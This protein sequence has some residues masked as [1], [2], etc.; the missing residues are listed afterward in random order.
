MFPNI[1]KITIPA[2]L[3]LVIWIV[4]SAVRRYSMARLQ[5]GVQTKMLE[6]FGSSH[7]LVGYVQSK[8]GRRFMQTLAL[9]QSTPYSRILGAV[10]AGVVLSAFGAGLLIVRSHVQQGNDGLLV[11]GTIALSLGIGFAISAVIS[12]MLSKTFGVLP[13]SQAD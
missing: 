5:A 8:E 3:V 11:F 7:D 1:E 4:F 6:T 10:Q 2:M 13:E 9:E 12:Y